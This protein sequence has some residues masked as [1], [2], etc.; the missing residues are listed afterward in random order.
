MAPEYVAVGHVSIKSN[1]FNFGILL[2]EIVSRRKSMVSHLREQVESL[3]TLSDLIDPIIK[4][5]CD[6]V[7]AVKCIRIGLLCTQDDPDDRP[8][9]SVV[10]RML[11]GD[12]IPDGPS[13]LTISVGRDLT[14]INPIGLIHN[15]ST[16]NEVILSDVLPR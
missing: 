3:R 5:S 16:I 13:Q 10:V 14:T 8:T 15:A 6:E 12:G 7:E 4:E 11:G 9:M 1:V 2:L